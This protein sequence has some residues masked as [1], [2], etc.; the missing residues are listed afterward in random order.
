MKVSIVMEDEDEDDEE[1]LIEQKIVKE[2]LRLK[3][4]LRRT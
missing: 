1:V 4:R 2:E 3:K